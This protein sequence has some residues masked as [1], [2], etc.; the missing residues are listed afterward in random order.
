MQYTVNSI[1]K[2]RSAL[3]CV[4]ATWGRCECT[5]LY[6]KKQK[7]LTNTSSNGF[8]VEPETPYTRGTLHKWR[9]YLATAL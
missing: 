1:V 4:F 6:S 3:A 9:G 7:Q 8:N 5:V 2:I